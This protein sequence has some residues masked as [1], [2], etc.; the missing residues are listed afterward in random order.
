M[1]SD[2]N[3]E[4][5]REKRQFTRTPE[6]YG[7]EEAPSDKP[8]F[9]VQKH[10]ASHLHYDFRLEVGGV[11]KS[12]AVPKGPSVDS[13]VKRLAMPTE[14]HPLDYAGFEGT[15]PEGN[16]G[17]GTVMVW[18]TGT[19]SNLRE[20]KPAG[21]GHAAMEQAVTEGKIE[22]RLDGKKLKGNYALIRTGLQ[23]KGWLLFKMKDEFDRPG[24]DIVVEEPDSALTGRTLNEIAGTKN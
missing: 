4:P 11:L 19:Y 1:P 13:K 8:I 17:A 9:V 6:P 14:D 3:L 20:T 2:R 5:Y 7:R 15:I 21:R 24:Y 22:V 16:Y 18:D 23:G 10:D 12:W